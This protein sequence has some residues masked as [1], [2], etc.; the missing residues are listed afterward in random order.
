MNTRLGRWVVL[1]FIY[2]GLVSVLYGCVEIPVHK[3]EIR[4]LPDEVS[5]KLSRGDT[6]KKV[7]SLLGTPLV[8]ARGFG[9]EIYKQSGLDI[10]IVM[11]PLPVPLPAQ[12]HPCSLSR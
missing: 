6:R 7:R 9:V 5:S 11:T 2:Y 12:W 8:D 10:A 3:T 1:A 4:N